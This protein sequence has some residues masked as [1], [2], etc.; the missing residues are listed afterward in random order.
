MDSKQIRSSNQQIKSKGGDP[1]GAI[2][3]L[4][5]EAAAKLRRETDKS[6]ENLNV[7]K[8]ESRSSLEDYKDM[9]ERVPLHENESVERK[10]ASKANDRRLK[11]IIEDD[12]ELKALGEEKERITKLISNYSKQTH[13][14][15]ELKEEIMQMI[16]CDDPHKYRK[17]IVGFTSPF[18]A[19]DKGERIGKDD[20]SK[21]YKFKLKENKE[22][23]KAKVQEIKNLRE[24][25][26]QRNSKFK[27]ELY[28]KHRNIMKNLHKKIMR[29]KDGDVGGSPQ[30]YLVKSEEQI[31]DVRNSKPANVPSLSI[32]DSQVKKTQRVPNK[33]TLESIGQLRFEELVGGADIF[34]PADVLDEDDQE[35]EDEILKQYRINNV[36]NAGPF[37]IEQMKPNISNDVT[38]NPVKNLQNQRS[39]TL[40][41]RQPA[42]PKPR[43]D[44]AHNNSIADKMMVVPKTLSKN[45]LAN[46]RSKGVL[47]HKSHEVVTSIKKKGPIS[48]NEKIY[49]N[50]LRGEKARMVDLPK[51]ISKSGRKQHDPYISD[52]P[53]RNSHNARSVQK[54]SNK[55]SMTQ[56]SNDKSYHKGI[57][58]NIKTRD[59]LVNNRKRAVG[60]VSVEMYDQAH[61]LESKTRR[62]QEERL[63]NILKMHDKNT[64]RRV[65][66]A[67][68]GRRL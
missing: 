30:A 10:P 58:T 16:Q 24:Q 17:Q 46:S 34:N 29:E 68:K 60:N 25:E 27:D 55:I 62:N 64:Q 1:H 4:E 53:K 21:R 35:S 23:L 57:V 44:R 8:I 37:P 47:L 28:H 18:G 40:D 38:F 13:S 20:R 43:Q 39:V 41:Q 52:S 48:D 42:P 36:N 66:I 26:K 31:Y 45:V 49:K 19:V 6:R 7:K 3:K 67:N 9:N 61:K 33:F 15:E 63:Q 2:Q 12:K 32:R 22:V 50:K 51:S 5:E 14:D 65:E 56:L 54:V 59:Q 11:A